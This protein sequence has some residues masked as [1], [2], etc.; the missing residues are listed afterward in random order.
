MTIA[1]PAPDATAVEQALRAFLVSILPAGVEAV[2][3]QVN[4][5][6]EPIGADY[7]VF[8]PLRRTR[9]RTNLNGFAD[10]LFTGSIAVT[11][12]T[13]SA[14][15]HG[16]VLIGNP[17]NGTG[18][19]SNTLVSSQLTGAPG[20]VGTYKVSVAQTLSSRPLATGA[21][22]YEQGTELVYQ[23]D[24][25]GPKSADYAQRITTLFRD[26]YATQFFADAG[27]AAVPLYA[28][29]ARQLA[30]LNAEQQSEDRWSVEVYLQANQV[31]T[32]YQQFADTLAV[33]LKNVDATYPP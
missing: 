30:F 12:L 19:A 9:L 8:W 22:T 18:V 7:V 32:G 1:G 14:I 31:V 16:A 20:G 17:L 6:P 24:A 33:E 26:E 3:G 4:R 27:G 23:V 28:D 21:Q 2:L 5:V 10:G 25:H 11:T 15:A 13:V 29:E